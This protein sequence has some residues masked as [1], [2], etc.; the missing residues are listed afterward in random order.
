MTTPSAYISALD[1]ARRTATGAD[2]VLTA[3]RDLAA[4]RARTDQRIRHVLAY[5]RTAVQPR[6]YRLADLADALGMSISGV[7]IAYGPTDIT[8]VTDALTPTS[9]ETP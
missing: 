1:A 6:P 8:A 4:Q 9:E 3:L 7:R 2:P 5:A